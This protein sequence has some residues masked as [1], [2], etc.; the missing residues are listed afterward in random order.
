M[1]W[2]LYTKAWMDLPTR[3]LGE[4]AA[5]LGFDAVELPIRPG[6]QVTP[7]TVVSLLGPTAEA[8]GE[9]GLS[10]MSCAGPLGPDLARACHDAGIGK[11][12]VMANFV[13]GGY[14]ASVEHW[15]RRLGEIADLVTSLGLEVSVQP[16]HGKWVPTTSGI[17]D[18]LADLPVENFTVA[19]DSAHAA[20]A[21]EL[22]PAVSLDLAGARLGILNLKD[23]LFVEVPEADRH[24][25]DPNGNQAYV[26]AYRPR[27]VPAGS[28]MSDWPRIFDWVADNG[29]NG[30][31]CLTAEYSQAQGPR[32]REITAELVATDLAWAK[33][34]AAGA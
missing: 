30:P 2:A 7:D 26:P 4:L 19:W 27:F 34:L 24:L 1:T 6:A 17:L 15:K 5:G 9:H 13:D 18:I 21:G 16:H 12:R 22:D 14:A 33:A 10:I 20:L 3:R 25:T 32:L 31:V 8:L 29:W 23:A 28:G 11:I